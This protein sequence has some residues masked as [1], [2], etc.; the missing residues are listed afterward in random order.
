MLSGN[1]LFWSAPIPHLILFLL[2]FIG[3]SSAEGSESLLFHVRR[4][5]GVD[6]LSRIGKVI[7]V[8]NLNSAPEVYRQ[9]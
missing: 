5:L 4:G 8:T 3:F 7:K 6:P 1:K 2:L 9:L